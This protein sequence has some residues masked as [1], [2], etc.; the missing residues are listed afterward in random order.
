MLQGGEQVCVE[1]E[2]NAEGRCQEKPK[3]YF[4]R[5][6]MSFDDRQSTDGRVSEG[7]K[8]RERE[9]VCVPGGATLSAADLCCKCNKLATL[10]LTLRQ[11]FAAESSNLLPSATRRKLQRSKFKLAAFFAHFH[12]P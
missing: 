11:S 12:A 4:A 8:E 10:H 2:N 6:A 3:T 7:D 9:E 5:P 1:S